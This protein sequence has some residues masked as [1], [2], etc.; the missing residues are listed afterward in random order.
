MIV[1]HIVTV[2]HSFAF[3]AHDSMLSA[4]Y[5]IANP[6]VCL[7]VTWVDQL[8]TVEV[9]I[10]QCSPYSS[11]SLSC[12]RYKFHPENPTGSPLPERGCQTRVGWGKEL[13]LS[14]FECF[15]QMAAQVRLLELLLMN[16]NSQLFARWRLC[17][18]LTP[19]SARLSCMFC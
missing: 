7:P 17:H 6:S 1:L 13:I 18:T 19:A 2:L 15:R 12:L 3:L 10:I 11:P 16:P 5:A 4:L 14:V 8:K 9:R